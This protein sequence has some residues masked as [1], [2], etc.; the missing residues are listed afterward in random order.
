[1]GAGRAALA[2]VGYESY[3]AAA[4]GGL[5]ISLIAAGFVFYVDVETQIAN[6]QT[7]EYELGG[8]VNAYNTLV[9][10]SGNAADRD[11]AA[12]IDV[13]RKITKCRTL[14]NQTKCESEYTRMLRSKYILLYT[15]G[16][17]KEGINYR[18]ERERISEALYGQYLKC[19][20]SGGCCIN[21]CK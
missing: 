17:G 9:K 20:E 5:G 18:I 7:I 14:I 8:D 4:R 15:L 12:I 11:G 2:T 19:L 1:V 6:Y 13:T 21:T 10:A 3:G 16:F